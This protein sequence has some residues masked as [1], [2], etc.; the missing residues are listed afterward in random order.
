MMKLGGRCTVQKYRPS[1][2][3][4]VIVDIFGGAWVRTPKNVPLG[5]DVGKISAGCLVFNTLFNGS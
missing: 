5:Y 2:N 1:S 3:F 4:G